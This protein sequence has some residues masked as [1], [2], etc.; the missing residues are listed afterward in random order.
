MKKIQFL[1]LSILCLSIISCNLGSGDGN[2]KGAKWSY[3]GKTGPEHWFDISDEYHSCGGNSQSPVNIVAAEKGDDLKPLFLDYS[4][5]T[6]TEILNNGHT[7][8]VAYK[9]GKFI[10]PNP[11]TFNGIDYNISQFHFHCKSE[12]TVDGKQYPM[13]IHFVHINEAKQLAVVALFVEEGTENEFMATLLASTPDKGVST[14]SEKLNINKLFP[15]DKS[16]WTF[17]GSLT[18]PPCSEGVKWYVLKTPIQASA[19]QI[20]K[21]AS[22]MP[23]NNFRPVQDLNGR[24]IKEF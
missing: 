6:S 12:N 24:I 16:Y 14:I 22:F 23:E 4:A 21:M 17:E 7:V 5:S 8:Q 15:Q 20:K 10:I 19:E 9:K 3:D 1:F 2:S 13:E 11:E 18:T